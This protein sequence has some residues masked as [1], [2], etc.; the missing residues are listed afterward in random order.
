[1]PDLSTMRSR[2]AAQSLIEKL[3]ALHDA[4]PAQSGLARLFGV[5]PLN[6]AETPW[7]VGAR[8]EIAVARALAGLPAEWTVLHSVPVG[9]KESD[10]DH[11]LVSPAGVF[12][13][14]TKHHSGKRIWV[15]GRGFLV[16]GQ[17]QPYVRNAES[18][19]ASVGRLI[20]RHLPDATLVRS[21]IVLVDPGSVR[22]R[23]RPELVTV[24]DAR[25]LV[26][27]LVTQPVMLGPSEVADLAHLL[28]NPAVWRETPASAADAPGRFAA[29]DAAVRSAAQRQ[30]LWAGG[31]VV[32]LVGAC[33]VV[34]SRLLGVA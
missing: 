32:L 8:G 30:T 7:Y 13:I 14:N 18:E 21:M 17:K 4:R 31:G 29:L 1:M 16:S 11:L 33:M 28:D 9:R 3:L 15:G 10:I 19:A 5:S 34:A 25:H 27:W 2:P 6:A 22:I 26:R 24:I 20:A 23:K 12:T